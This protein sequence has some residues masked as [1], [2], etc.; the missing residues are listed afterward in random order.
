MLVEKKDYGKKKFNGKN[1][2]RI[3]LNPLVKIIHG[4]KIFLNATHFHYPTI[5]K[6]FN[7]DWFE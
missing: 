4:N 7:T 5:D 1:F 6:T 2:K 3:N